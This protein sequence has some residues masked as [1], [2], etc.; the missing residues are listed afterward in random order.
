MSSVYVDNLWSFLGRKACLIFGIESA[1]A[2]SWMFITL[3][4][5]F[6]LTVVGLKDNFIPL[7]IVF[8]LPYLIQVNS[9]FPSIFFLV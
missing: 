1:S 8:A 6:I 3:F 5:R 7:G 2:S 4:I 9:I